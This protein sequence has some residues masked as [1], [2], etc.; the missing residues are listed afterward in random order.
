[1][2]K[3]S[4]VLAVSC[5]AAVAAGIYFLVASRMHTSNALAPS[6]TSKR[7]FLMPEVG[8]L[9]QITGYDY[10][11]IDDHTVLVNSAE[12]LCQTV[13]T[14]TGKT[15]QCI[16]IANVMKGAEIDPRNKKVATWSISPDSQ[17]ALTSLALS[18]P[19]PNLHSE[20]ILVKLD[21]THVIRYP[22]GDENEYGFFWG[23]DS[24]SWY[25]DLE[26]TDSKYKSGLAQYQIDPSGK[27]TRL[28]LVADSTDLPGDGTIHS[29]PKGQFAAVAA[30]NG[31]DDEYNGLTILTVSNGATQVVTQYEDL[32]PQ[33]EMRQECVISP[34]GTRVAWQCLTGLDI[35]QEISALHNHGQIQAQGEVYVSDLDG[36]HLQK[37]VEAKRT[38]MTD[39]PRSLQ[40]TPDGKKISYVYQG[41][42]WTVPAN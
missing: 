19:P 28:N 7:L 33:P 40:W 14:L 5:A 17:W 27:I 16:P 15:T 29:L 2:P 25:A 22:V 24:K 1:M 21:G 11:W 8:P 26:S 32:F 10:K 36:S 4:V 9:I 12:G 38:N 35:A 13:D 23:A 3:R 18:N 20:W 41:C 6:L 42:L 37:L 34:S 39:A 31:N 30:T